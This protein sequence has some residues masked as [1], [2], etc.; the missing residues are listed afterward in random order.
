MVGLG[1]GAG[2]VALLDNFP[3]LDLTVLEIDPAVI[4]LACEHFPLL[5]HYQDLGR[6]RLVRCDAER[7]LQEAHQR[8]ERWDVGFCD[9][10]QGHNDLCVSP[11]MLVSL[12]GACRDV[13][14]NLIDASTG[15]SIHGL[16]EALQ[17][18]RQPL[19]AIFDCQPSLPVTAPRNL[20][21]TTQVVDA[22]K[23]AGFTPFQ[24]RQGVWVDWVRTRYQTIIG[25]LKPL[26]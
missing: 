26:A 13:W 24:D 20:V 7:Y 4:D 11:L 2:A 1:S 19:R 3:A 8:G 16:Q 18:L 5:N 9:A 17:E 10:Y 15:P 22:N 6:L 23:L 12:L 25:T 14:F 21:C